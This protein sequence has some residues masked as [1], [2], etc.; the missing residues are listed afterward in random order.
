MITNINTEKSHDEII[1]DTDTLCTQLESGNP[2]SPNQDIIFSQKESRA[3]DP[4]EAVCTLGDQRIPSKRFSQFFEAGLKNSMGRLNKNPNSKTLLNSIAQ[5]H[6]KR[7][8]IDDAIEKLQR[9]YSIDNSFFPTI[10]NL[11]ECYSLKNDTQKAL[12]LYGQVSDDKR[13]DIRV[14]TNTALIHM[15]N[16]DFD[17][18]L[19]IL[20][21]AYKLYPKNHN[22]LNNLGIVYLTKGE[23]NKAIHFLRKAARR[24]CDD[25]TIFNNLGV[26]FAAINNTQKALTNF[27]IAYSINHSARS[28]IKNLA[29]AYQWV[30]DHESVIA[31]LDEYLAST[32]EDIE[33]RDFACFSYFEMG[34]YKKCLNELLK[35]LDFIEDSKKNQIASIYNNIAVALIKLK[36]FKEAKKYFLASYGLNQ[37]PTIETY[38]NI[39]NFFRS[40]NDFETLKVFLDASLQQYNNDPVLITFLGMHYSSLELYDQAKELFLDALKKDEKLLD[41]YLNLSVL[42]TDVYGDNDEALRFIKKGLIFHPNNV[43]LINNYAYCSIMNGDIAEARKI[44]DSVES[45]NDVHLNATRGLLHLRE[46]NAELG[47]RYYNQAASLSKDNKNLHSLVNQKKYL[48]LGNYHFERGE[49][50]LALQS[51]KKGKTFNTIEQYYKN[52]ILKL[53]QLIKNSNT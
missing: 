3:I 41:P 42:E 33:L 25:Y 44:I 15:K 10:A 38:Y 31:L 9:A 26:A 21:H 14:L 2:F 40:T 52:S 43:T 53:S 12:S 49:T 19:D 36:R 1:I 23:P 11:A 20:E 7:G 34:V 17:A 29:N 13:N 37:N 46:G 35:S 45:P 16:K 39:L 50:K 47:R 28:V 48:E 4:S 18:A 30:K 51:L 27:K 22:V 24:K 6:I 5:N 8:L 32:P